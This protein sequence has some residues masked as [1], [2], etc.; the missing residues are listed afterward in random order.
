MI[1]KS[2]CFSQWF[3]KQKADIHVTCS[4]YQNYIQSNV[5]KQYVFFEN[6]F[7][8]TFLRKVLPCFKAERAAQER[9]LEIL[10]EDDEEETAVV[11]RKN[12]DEHVE[13]ADNAVENENDG[14]LNIHVQI[15]C[16]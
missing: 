4:T 1:K 14:T 16:Y 2:F 13:I 15:F 11:S 6:K 3:C 5:N 7:D 8:E 12:S 9:G 10:D